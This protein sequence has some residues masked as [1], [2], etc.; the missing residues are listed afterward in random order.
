MFLLTGILHKGDGTNVY[1][2][3]KPRRLLTVLGNGQRRGQGCSS[4]DGL[5]ADKVCYC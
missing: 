5:A 4:C 2:S 1:L 3:E